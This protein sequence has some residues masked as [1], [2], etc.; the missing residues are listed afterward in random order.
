MSPR[1]DSDVSYLQGLLI[2]MFVLLV[3][4]VFLTLIGSFIGDVGGYFWLEFGSWPTR[5]EHLKWLQ[6]DTVVL[7]R[8]TQLA[9][10]LRDANEEQARLLGQVKWNRTSYQQISMEVRSATSLAEKRHKSFKRAVGVAMNHFIGPLS[11]DYKD[12]LPGG[13]LYRK[14]N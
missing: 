9:I 12:Y 11:T 8:L 7:P 3:A 6:R 4:T 14:S 2:E 13:Q 1:K 5:N 10:A